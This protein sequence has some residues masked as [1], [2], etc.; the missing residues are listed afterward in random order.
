MSTLVTV[1]DDGDIEQWYWDEVQKI[2]RHA[3][4]LEDMLYS[5]LE[6]MRK[7]PSGGYVNQEL[8]FG[9]TKRGDIR[10]A[11]KCLNHA[12]VL[13]NYTERISAKSPN[14]NGGP[15]YSTLTWS[16]IVFGLVG[17]VLLIVGLFVMSLSSFWV[18]FGL[19]ITGLVLLLI[20]VL[21]FVGSKRA[22]FASVA[23]IA[24]G[25]FLIAFIIL[26]F[27]LM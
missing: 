12:T 1:S 24:L 10:K 13:A 19:S 9:P 21:I 2:D 26:L 16:G 17:I 5:R 7:A 22:V 18:G 14:N 27:V 15:Q 20:G 8:G 4:Q 23:G 25:I 6:H 3:Q 11:E